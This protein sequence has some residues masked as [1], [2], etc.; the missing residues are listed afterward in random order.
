MVFADKYSRV[1]SGWPSGSDRVCG[2]QLVTSFGKAFGSG[3]SGVG[4]G[5][6]FDRIRRNLATPSFPATK[7]QVVIQ[8]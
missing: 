2:D 7:R 8:S 5:A 3:S 6:V 4:S 1:A